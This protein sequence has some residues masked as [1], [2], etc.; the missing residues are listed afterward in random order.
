MTCAHTTT[1]R[2]QPMACSSPLFPPRHTS[3]SHRQHP[4]PH[5]HTHTLPLC[6]LGGRKDACKATAPGRVLDRPPP[7]RPLMCDSASTHALPQTTRPKPT[8]LLRCAAWP[9]PTGPSIHPPS[10]APS[11][12]H[13]LSVCVRSLL[14][15]L[16]RTP[17]THPRI[18][19]HPLTPTHTHS[20][21]PAP[22]PAPVLACCLLYTT[23]LHCSRPVPAAIPPARPC[24]APSL[25]NPFP[26]PSAA[27]CT[28]R[29]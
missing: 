6:R 23:C 22:A 14:L 28:R 10:V 24:I 8:T 16:S 5:T 25:T 21:P 2:R 11:L 7:A 13:C 29:C 18:H 27:L 17:P 26:T 1:A 9:A 20:R 15:L 19:S 12:S 4:L 3:T